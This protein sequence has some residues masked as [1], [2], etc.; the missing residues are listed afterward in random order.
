MDRIHATQLD[1]NMA[2]D[3][4]HLG[5]SSKSYAVTEILN[6]NSCRLGMRLR[7]PA[8]TKVYRPNTLIICSVSKS[9]GVSRVLACRRIQLSPL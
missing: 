3:A 5:P 1:G 6:G 8:W 9:R 2:K 4:H 7:V